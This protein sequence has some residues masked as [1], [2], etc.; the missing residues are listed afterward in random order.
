MSPLYVCNSFSFGHVCRLA[1]EAMETDARHSK[2]I[3]EDRSAPTPTLHKNGV[4]EKQISMKISFL[5]PARGKT[6]MTTTTTSIVKGLAGKSR[7]ERQ[8]NGGRREGYR[9]A[10]FMCRWRFNCFFVRKIRIAHPSKSKCNS[11]VMAPNNTSTA[12]E[13]FRTSGKMLSWEIRMIFFFALDKM[14]I[15]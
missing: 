6:A 1:A 11:E 15:W 8:Q 2:R 9:M 10:L 5:L 14:L 12:L 13:V 3:P 7:F 4:T